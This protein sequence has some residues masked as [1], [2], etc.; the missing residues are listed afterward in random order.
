MS[1]CLYTVYGCICAMMGELG[2]LA[3]AYGLPSLKYLLFSL[4]EKKFTDSWSK[5]ISDAIFNLCNY[6][7]LYFI[8]FPL[9]PT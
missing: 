2:S 5:Y 6:E 7:N 9:G 4:Y 1:I 8:R 3:E